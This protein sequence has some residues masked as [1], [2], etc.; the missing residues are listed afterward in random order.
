MTPDKCD[1]YPKPI[2]SVYYCGCKVIL[3]VGEIRDFPGVTFLLWAKAP[4]THSTKQCNQ[5]G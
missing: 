2:F 1:I 4:H 3:V 5:F